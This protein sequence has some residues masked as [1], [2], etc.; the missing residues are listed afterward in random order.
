MLNKTKTCNIKLHPIVLLALGILL[1]GLLYACAV[2]V[3][4]SID[5]VTITLPPST[6]FVTITPTSPTSSTSDWSS[7]PIIKGTVISQ[8]GLPAYN[9]E[10]LVTY[11]S[12]NA[13]GIID[14]Q[15]TDTQ[16]NYE[17]YNYTVEADLLSPGDPGPW[18]YDAN[19]YYI[20]VALVNQNDS[21]A[22]DTYGP[23]PDAVVNAVPGQTVVAPV[24]HLTLPDSDY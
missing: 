16:G 3:G 5:T 13:A 24:I 19:T 17:F 14:E 10:V 22:A 1:T 15:Y 23:T 18:E 7:I 6:V 8:S 12:P 9:V 4:H 21:S 20:Y 11:A 2:P